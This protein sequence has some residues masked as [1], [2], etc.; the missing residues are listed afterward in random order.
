MARLSLAVVA[1]VAIAAASLPHGARAQG[2]LAGDFCNNDSECMSRSCG[3]DAACIAT[4]CGMAVAKGGIGPTMPVGY[5]SSSQFYNPARVCTFGFGKCAKAECCDTLSCG[6]GVPDL[7]KATYCPAGKSFAATRLCP[8]GVCSSA[9]CCLQTRCDSAGGVGVGRRATFCPSGFMFNNAGLCAAGQGRCTADDCCALD[10]RTCAVAAAD[11]TL[12]LTCPAPS[13]LV[14]SRIYDNSKASDQGGCCEIKTCATSVLDSAKNSFCPSGYVFNGSPTCASGTCTTSDCCKS[15]KGFCDGPATGATLQADG[16]CTCPAGKSYVIGFGCACSAGTQLV[17][18]ACSP[19]PYG[20]YLATPTAEQKCVACPASQ[21]TTAAPGADSADH[22]VNYCDKALMAGSGACSNGGT[23]ASLSGDPATGG[24]FSCACPAAWMGYGATTT[25]NC[26]APTTLLRLRVLAASGVNLP[27]G[28]QLLVKNEALASGDPSYALQATTPLACSLSA[29]P[30]TPTVPTCNIGG[31]GALWAGAAGGSAD[32]TRK[33]AGT[34][35]KLS[36]NYQQLI[37]S[38]SAPDADFVIEWACS[39]GVESKTA[40]LSVVL[41]GPTNTAN[42]MALVCTAIV[43]HAAM[44]TPVKLQLAAGSVVPVA[45]NSDPALLT[46][47]QNGPICTLPMPSTAGATALAPECA[48]NEQPFEG[49]KPGALGVTNVD[50]EKYTVSWTCGSTAVATDVDGNAATPNLPSP[51]QAVLVCSANFQAKTTQMTFTVSSTA[52]API[53]LTAM[54]KGMNEACALT[55]PAGASSAAATLSCPVSNLNSGVATTLDT[56]ADLAKY[57]VDFKCKTSA[58]VAVNNRR[59][60][61]VET[62]QNGKTTPSDCAVTITALPPLLNLKINNVANAREFKAFASQD[63]SDTCVVTSSG[64]AVDCYLKDGMMPGVKTALS[65]RA[66]DANKYSLIWT[67]DDAAAGPAVQAQFSNSA[68]IVLNANPNT[69]GVVAVKCVGTVIS[70]ST[71]VTVYFETTS[72]EADALLPA[73][74]EARVRQPHQSKACSVTRPTGSAKAP[75]CEN[76][77]LNANPTTTTLSTAG[78]DLSK[79]QV[80]WS[81]VSSGGTALATTLVAAGVSTVQTLGE[82]KPAM[83]CKASVSVKPPVLRLASTGAGPS[84]AWNV[85]ARQATQGRACYVPVA[86]SSSS[87]PATAPECPLQALLPARATVLAAAN[88]DSSRWSVAWSCVRSTGAAVTTLSD[89]LASNG[90]LVA[91]SKTLTLDKD[92]NAGGGAITCTAAVSARGDVLLLAA[93]GNLPT[94]NTWTLTAKQ[95]T[96]ASACTVGAAAAKAGSGAAPS[97]GAGVLAFSAGNPVQ[98]GATGLPASSVVTWSCSAPNVA[99]AVSVENG[100]EGVATMTPPA[101]AVTTCT[102]NVVAQTGPFFQIVADKGVT[103]SAFQGVGDKALE[104]MC[105]VTSDKPNTPAACSSATP[106]TTTTLVATL[107]K[108]MPEDTIVRFSCK[109]GVSKATM[110]VSKTSGLSAIVTSP[111]AIET[112]VCTATV[113]GKPPILTVTSNVATVLTAASENG[114][115]CTSSTA[116]NK[117]VCDAGDGTGQLPAKA[118]VVL[119]QTGYEEKG[120]YRWACSSSAAGIGRLGDEDKPLESTATITL[121]ED[122]KSLTCSLTYTVDKPVLGRLLRRMLL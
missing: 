112:I 26:D 28:L 70:R 4:T 69:D 76:E 12:R 121:P 43:S 108:D 46:F 16:S 52:D 96:Q 51:G 57:L 66:L 85:T 31:A 89:T 80:L 78:V 25:N 98:L 87:T 23:C 37:T 61:V 13:V 5:C 75:F 32:D 19:C 47:A 119:T 93:T 77:G 42:N 45:A 101:N 82:D 100:N 113:V 33:F 65:P 36:T 106:G 54:Q 53:Q 88:L 105:T 21:P 67:C 27:S 7:N 58:G 99:S 122:G 115:K 111:P 71:P 84:T 97:C 63:A 117:L 110:P 102:A 90:A 8:G 2:G 86:A 6:A 10:T 56:N 60:A 38:G 103:F 109:L 41:P 20:T 83:V 29:N 92:A 55:I 114:A 104:P 17:N 74:A 30:T 50:M 72:A 15:S 116:T 91:N 62:T 9:D 24:S 73:G 18:G 1:L 107:D 40:E 94:E 79:V 81:C 11:P 3:S 14:G 118:R 95:P 59:S 68:T 48:Y 39:D 120:Y 44:S 64:T 35:V 49:G 22:C 34:K